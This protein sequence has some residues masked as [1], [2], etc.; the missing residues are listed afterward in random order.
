MAHYYI[1]TNFAMEGKIG[2]VKIR[3]IIETGIIE[4]AVGIPLIGFAPLRVET[5]ITVCIIVMG[6]LAVFGVMG[7][8]RLSLFQFI[9]DFFKYQR[10]HQVY[11]E[12]KSSDNIQREKRLMKKKE[13]IERKQ[14][15]DSRTKNLTDRIMEQKDKRKLRKEEG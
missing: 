11:G 2:N 10:I 4:A 7:I 6:V 12:P 3:N 8:N 9:A 13:K 5:K 1:P 15:R 14:K